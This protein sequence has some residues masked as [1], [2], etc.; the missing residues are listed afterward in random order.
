MALG[1]IEWTEAAYPLDFSKFSKGLAA[2]SPEFY[3]AKMSGELAINLGRGPVA[4]IDDAWELGQS[5]TIEKYL[6]RRL[7]LYG[8]NEIEAAQIDMFT[9]HIRDIKDKYKAAKAEADKAAG[10]RK[11]FSETMP[12]FMQQIEASL[13]PSRGDAV[14]GRSLSL[15]DATLL[16]LIKDFFDDKAGAAGSIAKCPRLKASVEA[17]ENHPGIAKYR[18]RRTNAAT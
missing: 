6:A 18:A 7:G 15:A 13:P 14:I 1:G 11:F 10:V 5:K 12:A 3:A 16:V 17:T 4:V 2:A 8:A 9:E